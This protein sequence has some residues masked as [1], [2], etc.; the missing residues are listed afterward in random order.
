MTIR[1]V[2]G[3]S[4][5]DYQ[6]GLTVNSVGR[7]PLDDDQVTAAGV[8]NVVSA[9]IGDAPFASP[10]IARR[11]DDIVLTASNGYHL[12]YF[13]GSRHSLLVLYVW[14]DR[15]VGNLAMTQRRIH[16]LTDGLVPA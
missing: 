5:V 4:L 6:T 9:T 15:I 7:Q 11:L 16:S 3:A 13:V 2:L 8:G 14:L 12:V 10:G 1:G